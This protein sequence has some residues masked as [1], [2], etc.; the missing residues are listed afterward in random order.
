MQKSDA[1]RRVIRIVPTGKSNPRFVP[2]SQ[3]VERGT[4]V[5]WRNLTRERAFLGFLGDTKDIFEGGVAELEVPPQGT[6][7][8]LTVR[9]DARPGAYVY[10]GV[11]QTEEGP[12]IAIEGHS[13]PILIVD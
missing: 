6:S 7:S 9:K 8:S 5:S 2:P 12:A 1:A 11:V 13:H 10:V 3:V 4:T